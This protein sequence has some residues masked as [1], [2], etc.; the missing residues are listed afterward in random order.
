MLFLFDYLSKVKYKVGKTSEVVE[1]HIYLS[2]RFMQLYYQE[3]NIFR[4]LS[5]ILI[6]SSQRI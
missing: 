5:N 4:K 6:M 1:K 3:T 2:I